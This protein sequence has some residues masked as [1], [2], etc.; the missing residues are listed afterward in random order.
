[1]LDRLDLYGLRR[2]LPS[3]ADGGARSRP[4]TN[5]SDGGKRAMSR[6]R[7]PDPRSLIPATYCHL[8]PATCH[9]FEVFTHLSV[10]APELHALGVI[11]GALADDARHQEV[12]D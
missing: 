11:H 6:E 10:L 12:D 3:D 5:S 4:L 2:D 1:M 7:R 9:L 8:P